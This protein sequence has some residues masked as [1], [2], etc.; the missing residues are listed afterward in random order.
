MW[1]GVDVN[2]ELNRVAIGYS[3]VICALLLLVGPKTVKLASTSVLLAIETM[4]MQGFYWIGKPASMFAPAAIGTMAYDLYDVSLDRKVA[5][6]KEKIVLFGAELY[7][8]G[9]KGVSR[10]T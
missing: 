5:E 7:K 2:A 8:R 4:A 1:F 3:Q 9:R 6:T 10:E